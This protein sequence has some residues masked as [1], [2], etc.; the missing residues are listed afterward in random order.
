MFRFANEDK[1]IHAF[2][3][4]VAVLAAKSVGFPQFGLLAA[5]IALLLIEIRQ[6]F[7]P[8]RSPDWEDVLL[9]MVGA[10]MAH[11]MLR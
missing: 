7:Q 8:D 1:I 6:T 2:I 3:G 10:L 4:A 9:G 5:F 11:G